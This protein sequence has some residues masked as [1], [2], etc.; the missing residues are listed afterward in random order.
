MPRTYTTEGEAGLG[1]WA[2]PL[3]IDGNIRSLQ[4]LNCNKCENDEV[5]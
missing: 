3:K 2:Q 1:K 5:Q 4:L